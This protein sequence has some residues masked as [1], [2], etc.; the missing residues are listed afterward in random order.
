MIGKTKPACGFI[1]IATAKSRNAAISRRS[2]CGPVKSRRSD[3]SVNTAGTASTCPHTA[4]SAITAGLKSTAAATS[5]R[6]GSRRTSE[7]GA[8][9]TASVPAIQASPRSARIAGSL[10]SR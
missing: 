2:V 7:A 4:L 6:T 1:A 9:R 8:M 5:A 10:R 3:H